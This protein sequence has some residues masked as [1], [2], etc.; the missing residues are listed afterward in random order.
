LGSGLIR[1]V[2]WGGGFGATTVD[3]GNSKQPLGMHETRYL[4]YQL[5]QEFFHQQ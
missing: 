3:G 5:V 2:L 4:P 1:G